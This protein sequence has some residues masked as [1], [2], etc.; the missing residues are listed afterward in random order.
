MGHC[1]ALVSLHSDPVPKAQTVGLL[2]VL[3]CV[4]HGTRTRTRINLRI[5]DSIK[6]TNYDIRHEL[7]G[8]GLQVEERY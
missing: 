3:L 7:G 5:E 2:T 6:D 4:H 8:E 1:S